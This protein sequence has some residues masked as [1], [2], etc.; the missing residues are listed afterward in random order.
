MRFLPRFNSPESE[1]SPTLKPSVSNG[2][3]SRL[4]VDGAAAMG[5]QTGCYWCAPTRERLPTP[6]MVL[7]A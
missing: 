1:Q 5:V 6:G 7:T 3:S 4:E 2:P